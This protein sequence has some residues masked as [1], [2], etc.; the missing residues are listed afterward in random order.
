MQPGPDVWSSLAARR[1]AAT[2]LPNNFELPPPPL[3]QLHTKFQQPF[4]STGQNIPSE[5]HT[6]SGTSVTSAGNLLTPPN[7]VPTDAAVSPSPATFGASSSSSQF[8][9]LNAT[10]YWPAVHTQYPPYQSV[11]PSSWAQTRPLFSPSSLNSIMRGTSAQGNQGELLTPGTAY[12]VNQLPPFTPSTLPVPGQQTLPAIPPFP[13]GFLYPPPFLGGQS[14]SPGMMM[15]NY[16]LR[17]LP[18]PTYYNSPHSSTPSQHGY[19]FPMGPSPTSASP[20]STGNPTM[21]SPRS[22]AEEVANM[23]AHSLSPQSHNR[24]SSHY[25]LPAI[26]QHSMPTM[27]SPNGSLPFG[28]IGGNMVGQMHPHAGSPMYSSVSHQHGHR[29]QQP[30]TERPFKCDQCPQS[31]NRNHDLKRHKRIHLAVKPF[32]C[33]HCDKSFSRKDALKVTILIM[34]NERVT[35]VVQRHILVKGCGKPQGESNSSDG[36]GSESPPQSRIESIH[37]NPQDMGHVQPSLVTKVEA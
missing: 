9:P 23:S 24:S 6:V 12:E 3:A 21:L 30:Q 37:F 8:P 10:H 34:H 14:T 2:H 28:T 11:S 15:D 27:H 32:P 1:P 35:N 7:S 17:P 4:G 25:S 20:P 22:A 16:G 33:G 13:H 29:E 19:Q 26:G 31:F 18:T 5:T 36:K